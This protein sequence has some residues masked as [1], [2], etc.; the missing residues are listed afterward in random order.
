MTS[1]LDSLPTLDASAPAF[2]PESEGV[3]RNA[4]A[5]PEQPK[6]YTRR[7]DGMMK[8][9]IRTRNAAEAIPELPP[10][11]WA[12]H[13]ILNGFWDVWAVVPRTL[14]LIAPATIAEI[15]IST[16]GYSPSTANELFALMDTGKIGR[17]TF[18]CSHY[19]KSHYTDLADATGRGLADRGG[20]FAVSRTHA[21]V[22][23]METT[24]SRF[25]TFEG[26]GNLR[27]CRNVEQF[28]LVH[29]RG[30]VE[31][32]RGWMLDLLGRI[33]ADTARAA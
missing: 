4:V 25:L 28:C 32:H 27:A 20:R 11:G 24:D 30:L 31:F 10:V 18:L 29:D 15:N 5:L 2:F 17:A 13:G 14:E 33:E 16:L 26:S 23:C 12:T 19:F 1:W 21:K 3:Q 8:M 6:S 7:L 22:I 9:A